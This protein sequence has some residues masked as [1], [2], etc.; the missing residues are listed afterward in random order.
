MFAP[1][2]WNPGAGSGAPVT[3]RSATASARDGAGRHA[4]IHPM[5]GPAPNV[6]RLESAVLVP[7]VSYGKNAQAPRQQH[8]L[9]FV[10]DG[11]S[12]RLR[13]VGGH[14]LVTEFSG[15]WAQDPVADALEV[16]LGRRVGSAPPAPRVALFICAECGDLGC[17]AITARMEVTASTVTWSDFGWEDTTPGIEP[18][19][20]LSG[21]LVFDREAYEAAFADVLERVAGLPHDEPLPRGRRSLRFWRRGRAERP[22]DPGD[23]AS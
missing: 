2:P 11:T 4:R 9:D 8:F 17:G 16:F 15:A 10:V 19:E 3:P 14:E 23:G 20:G 21:A 5:T 22:G 1:G 12:L 6:L 13:A 18:V 7:D